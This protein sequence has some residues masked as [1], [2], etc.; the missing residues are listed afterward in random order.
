M[1]NKIKTSY[2]KNTSRNEQKKVKLQ[3]VTIEQ[4]L[5][6]AL[7]FIIE[8]HYLSGLSLYKKL[9]WNEKF[10]YEICKKNTFWDRQV[11][12]IFSTTYNISFDFNL[13][14]LRLPCICS[15]LT[16]CLCKF[17]IK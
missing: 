1:K 13:I 10:V 5:G 8:S 11:L 7:G 9:K 6:Y 14:C 16:I 15:M 17:V 3:L 4:P 2:Q 12:L